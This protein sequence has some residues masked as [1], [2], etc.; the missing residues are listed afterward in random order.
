MAARCVWIPEKKKTK[1]KRKR[2]IIS[3]EKNSLVKFTEFDGIYERREMERGGKKEKNGNARWWEGIRSLKIS[4]TFV[5]FGEGK[6]NKRRESGG[7][8]MEIENVKIVW[9][10]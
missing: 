8:G 1:K 4:V 10:N 6:T 9:R 3:R 5:R 2:T 7:R